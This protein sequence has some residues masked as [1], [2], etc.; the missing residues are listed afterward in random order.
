[1]TR[2]P[3]GRSSTSSQFYSAGALP[4]STSLPLPV[5]RTFYVKPTGS[6]SRSGD[7]WENA[8]LTIQKAVTAA[9]DGSQILIHAGEY[10]EQVTIPITSSNL[11]LTGV[12]GR[13]SVFIA[14]SASNPRALTVHGSDVTVEN[15]GFEGDGTG[16]GVLALGRRFRAI[17]CKFEGGADAL[18]CGPAAAAD[19]D[20]DGN[21]DGS[22][23]MYFGCEFAW[24]TNGAVIRGSDYGA[25]TQCRMFDCFFHDN[26]KH[27]IDRTGAGATASILFRD[28]QIERCTMLRN[29][30]GTAPTMFT[31]LD[32][33]NGNTGIVAGCIVAY[34]TNEADVI[35]LGTGVLWV[36]NYTEAGVTAAR[37]S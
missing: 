2:Y 15:I 34:A 36:G 32:T 17:D 5:G 27:I 22:D 29:E 37:P 7:S 1:M 6:N 10:D 12:G 20:D 19:V 11:R 9:P 23:Q 16:G 24:A 14:P 18:I 33:D 26:D 3:T 21:N 31:D 4:G 13:G 25:V 30:D 28:L 8:F 35:K